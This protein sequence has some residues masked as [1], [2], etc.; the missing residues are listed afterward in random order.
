MRLYFQAEL[1]D[2]RLT[3]VQN[4]GRHRCGDLALKASVAVVTVDG[5]SGQR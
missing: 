5:F 1:S 4:H 2:A 3:D